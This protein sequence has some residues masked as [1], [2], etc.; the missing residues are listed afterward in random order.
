MTTP[1]RGTDRG[2]RRS[3]R[4]LTPLQKY[5]I[6]LQ[7]V[8][9]E[10]NDG[11][12]GRAVAGGPVDD[13]ADPHCGQRGRAGSVGLRSAAGRP[14]RESGAP[15]ARARSPS[16]GPGQNVPTG[17]D[18][19]TIDRSG[20]GNPMSCGCLYRVR[21]GRRR[22]RTWRGRRQTPPPPAAA[23][24]SG[25]AATR[26]GAGAR[27]GDGRVVAAALGEAVERRAHVGEHVEQVAIRGVHPVAERR[28]GNAVGVGRAVQVVD[29]LVVAAEA[30]A[31]ATAAAL[32]LP[33]AWL[34]TFDT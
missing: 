30:R 8:R 29:L 22:P 27:A 11:G 21:A 13:H 2:G 6:F 5:E 14:G 17:P 7:L 23:A 4:F 33:G 15:G 28:E 20:S 16:A 9:Q 25:R 26:Q 1:A 19:P 10:G 3:K 34:K 12:G 31:L 18:R 32:S 24:V